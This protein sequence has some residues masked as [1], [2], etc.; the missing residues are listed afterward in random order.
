[1][2]ILEVVPG[3]GGA[4]AI[5]AIPP[6][7]STLNSV[8]GLVLAAILWKV[9]GF[10]RY[11]EDEREGEGEGGELGGRGRREASSSASRLLA[12]DH[13]EPE[14]RY[15][16]TSPCPSASSVSFVTSLVLVEVPADLERLGG[17]IW[18]SLLSSRSALDRPPRE[19][20]D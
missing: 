3:V 4:C 13:I 7:R 17:T 9:R 1:M 8:V 5:C 11:D 19:G 10:E 15:V 2:G 18:L 12:G 16:E 20:V 6:V 14:E